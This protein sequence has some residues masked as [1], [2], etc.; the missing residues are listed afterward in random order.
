MKQYRSSAWLRFLLPLALLLCV[1]PGA[2]AKNC[3]ILTTQPINFGNYDPVA[4][5]N[6]DTTGTLNLRCANK[7]P[8]VAIKIDAGMGGS[9]HPRTMQG[10][11]DQ[12]AYNL[13]T[14]AARVTVWGDGTSGTDFLLFPELSHLVSIPIYARAPLGQPVGVGTYVDTVVI[15]VEW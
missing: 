7:T 12:L 13:Y 14:D 6:L 11:V 3:R 5:G 9:F 2:S 4:S 10:P 1:V 15:T 8:N